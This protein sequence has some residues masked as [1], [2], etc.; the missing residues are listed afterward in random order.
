MIEIEPEMGAWPYGQSFPE[1]VQLGGRIYRRSGWGIPYAHTVAQYREDVPE[2]SRHLHV[3]ED[4]NYIVDHLD[5]ANPDFMPVWH[6]LLDVVQE[7]FRWLFS[8]GRL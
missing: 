1:L 4:G 2:R 8:C 6:L 7:P 3:L 5:E